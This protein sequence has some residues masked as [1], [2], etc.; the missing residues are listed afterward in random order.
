MKLLFIFTGGTIGSVLRHDHISPDTSRVISLPE[1][2]ERQYGERLCYDTASPYLVLSEYSTGEHL[3]QLCACVAARMRDGYDG[4]VVTHGTDTLQYAAAALSYALADTPVPICLVSSNLPLDHPEAN[5][6]AHLHAALCFIQQAHTP[7]VFVPYR[8][9][10]EPLRIHRGSR[11]LERV[12][13]SDRVCSV[14]ERYY[15]TVSADGVF[16]KNPAYREL[17]DALT[18]IGAIPLAPTA[19]EILCVHPYP[20]YLYPTPESQVRY[21]LHHTYHA[22]TLNTADPE[23]KRFFALARA[24]GIPVFVT[25]VTAGTAYESAAT[26]GEL[27]L[28][29][30]WGI[31]P[32]AAFVKLWLLHQKYGK[33]TG[34]LLQR[35]L[36][37]DLLPED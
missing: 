37:G 22:G 10:G 32:I 29:P 12:A 24:R 21:V 23:A 30:V 8:N 20:G 13:F 18:P 16:C 14:G 19:R 33:V 3:S 9:Q 6:L 28:V 31:A 4:I 2:Y 5:G 25:G 7:G 27:G 17:P 34:E 35:P 1:L 11:L 26:F 36:G 15:G